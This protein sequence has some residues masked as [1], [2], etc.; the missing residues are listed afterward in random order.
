MRQFAHRISALPLL[1]RRSAN[2]ILGYGPEGY[3][4]GD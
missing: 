3:L 4:V 1:D 2:E